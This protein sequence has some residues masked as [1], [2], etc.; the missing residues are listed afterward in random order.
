MEALSSSI[1]AF[2]LA[3]IFQTSCV[4]IALMTRVF[5]GLY[6]GKGELKQIGPCVWQLIWFS[7]LSLIITL[8]LSFW[9]AFFYFK[10]TA[11][12]QM[13]S[14]YFN[15][16]IFGNFLFP[17]NTTLTSFYLGRGKTMFVTSVLI[18]SYALHLALCWMLI[19]GIEGLIPSLGIRG[20]ALAKCLSMG[21]C[22]LVFFG[23]FL[24][25]KNREIYGTG[26]WQ[27]SPAAL[28]SYIRP[29]MVR[30]FGF[31]W[32]KIGWALISYLMIKKGGAYLDVI[33][34]GGTVNALFMFIV[35]G[36]YQAVLTIVP[37]LLGNKNYTEIWR[38]CRSSAIYICI[39]G[40]V[41]A[42]PLLMYPQLLIHF[43]GV[44]TRE[45]FEKTFVTINHWTW[46]YFVALAIQMSLCGLIIAVGELKI[47]FYVVLFTVLTSLL[48]VY[49]TMHF[50]EWNPDKLWLIMALENVI[51]AFIFLQRLRQRKW[52]KVLLLDSRAT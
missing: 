14:S 44:S 51:V 2:Y 34:I 48:P 29:G 4:A 18:A 50:W 6:Q 25:K 13:G 32:S 35:M 15:I 20:A 42:V 1:N 31:F 47:Q 45:I 27:I 11:I 21:G 33:T 52:E 46:F 5:V 26:S 17:L 8:P 40:I 30:A 12:E 41:V 16:L 19:F 37:N 10:N 7:L 36:N 23:A 3:F 22:C 38:L 24:K 49:L 43:F 39:I 28:W 9:S